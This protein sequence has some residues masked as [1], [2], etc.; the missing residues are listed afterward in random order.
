MRERL[1]PRKLETVLKIRRAEERGTEE[2]KTKISREKKGGEQKEREVKGEVAGQCRV[3]GGGEGERPLPGNNNTW[4]R[5]YLSHLRDKS[6]ISFTL[7]AFS[8]SIPLST[9]HLS[10]S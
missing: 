4:V 9:S 8:A 3:R 10:R 6:F 2:G 1:G 5:I 7:F